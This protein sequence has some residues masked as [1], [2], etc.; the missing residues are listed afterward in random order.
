MTFLLSHVINQQ[1]KPRNNL[2]FNCDAP[3][4]IPFLV[5]HPTHILMHPRVHRAHRLK[6]AALPYILQS[7]NTFVQRDQNNDNLY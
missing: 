1:P 3:L 4:W 7:W 5:V 2:L 6:T